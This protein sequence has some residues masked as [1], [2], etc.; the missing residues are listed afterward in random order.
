MVS[1]EQ[2][3]QQHICR[4]Q[5][6]SQ[7]GRREHLLN[8]CYVPGNV[9]VIVMLCLAFP[10]ISSHLATSFHPVIHL[11]GGRVSR[12]G[13]WWWWSAMAGGLQKPGPLLHMESM[14]LESASTGSRGYLLNRS[15]YN[16]PNCFSL[17]RMFCLDKS[18]EHGTICPNALSIESM[19]QCHNQQLHSWQILRIS[20]FHLILYCI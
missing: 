1:T 10:I 8:A 2:P 19:T 6:Q 3:S 5:C 4:S 20:G 13:N 11:K 16:K 7:A 12:Y 17:P 18:L 14:D 15:L 9:L